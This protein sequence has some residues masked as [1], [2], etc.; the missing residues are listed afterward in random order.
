MVASS[1]RPCDVCCQPDEGARQVA[2]V[3]DRPSTR[4]PARR[5]LERLQVHIRWSG[6]RLAYDLDDRADRVRVYQQVLRE[7]TEDDVRFF[8][9]SAARALGRARAPALGSARV[10]GLDRAPTRGVGAQPHR[11][12]SGASSRM[13]P[14]SW[15]ALS[16]YAAGGVIRALIVDVGGVLVHLDWRAALARWDAACGLQSGTVLNELFRDFDD[17]VLVGRRNA[18]QHWRRRA[19]GWV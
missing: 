16:S 2:A 7:G 9:R 14:R 3:L 10:G 12:S 11:R 17:S 4:R 18:D 5:P 13:S 8:V 19:H 6:P 1:A 15:R